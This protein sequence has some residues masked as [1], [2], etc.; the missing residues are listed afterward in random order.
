M[1]PGQCSGV[2]SDRTMMHLSHFPFRR[3]SWIWWVLRLVIP[4][5]L[6]LRMHAFPY[7]RHLSSL[8][9]WTEF[10]GR[11]PAPAA[12]SVFPAPFRI[13]FWK[14]IVEWARRFLSFS[15]TLNAQVNP[16]T[17]GLVGNSR[18]EECFLKSKSNWINISV[19]CCAIGF[20]STFGSISHSERYCLCSRCVKNKAGY[21]G[22]SYVTWLLGNEKYSF[23]ELVFPVMSRSLQL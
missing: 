14:F 8:Q 17:G 15:P 10:A 20:L 9:R 1:K 7:G 23:Q 21:N 22:A 12:C 13:H 5:G 16:Q 18:D 2:P 3:H 6:L 11:K 4:G 19:K